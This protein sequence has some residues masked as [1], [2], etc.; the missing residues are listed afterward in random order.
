ML[1]LDCLL[2]RLELHF[3]N[4]TTVPHIKQFTASKSDLPTRI[5]GY[6]LMTKILL[7]HRLDVFESDRD[8]CYR[9]LVR[10]MSF[11]R[12][13]RIRK[14]FMEF[15]DT[16][17]EPLKEFKTR[18]ELEESDSS[19]TKAVLKE[20]FPVS[21]IA[22]QT[23]KAFKST[24]KEITIEVLDDVDDQVAIEAINVLIN[25]DFLF[26]RATMENDFMARL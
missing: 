4:L 13:W 14:Q 19:L 7:A 16:F 8:F 1:V 17:L 26:S 21:M 22:R 25:F 12:G 20:R 10:Q 3:I 11:D 2:P 15:I 18:L 5:F 23:K 24:L 6:E 9:R